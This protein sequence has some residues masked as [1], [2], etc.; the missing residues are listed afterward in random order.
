M[1]VV[2][3]ALAVGLCLVAWGCRPSSPRPDL[4]ALRQELRQLHAATVAA[5]LEGDA[6]FFARDLGEDYL[7]VS[8]TEFTHPAPEEVRARFRRYLGTTAFSR[9]ETT[10]GPVVGV[11]DDGSVGW[12]IVRVEVEGG[13]ATAA[14]DTVPVDFA[15]AWVQ[16]FRRVDGRWVAVANVSD[17]VPG[18]R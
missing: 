4:E 1:N 3:R 7:V 17:V 15:S 12:I 9:Y 13:R 16:L 14:G 6:D 11:S 5:H 10:D 18:E 8:G 2:L